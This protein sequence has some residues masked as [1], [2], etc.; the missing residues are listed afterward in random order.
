MTPLA[1]NLLVLCIV[2]REDLGHGTI[3]FV[4]TWRVIVQIS[5]AAFYVGVHPFNVFI[6]WFVSLNVSQYIAFRIDF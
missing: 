6:K 1:M 4:R 3:V 2:P 5:P